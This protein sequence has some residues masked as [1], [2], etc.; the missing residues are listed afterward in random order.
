MEQNFRKRRSIVRR[1]DYFSVPNK[2]AADLVFDKFEKPY[3]GMLSDI[4]K[5]FSI[6]IQTVSDWYKR[7]KNDPTWR[8]YIGIS[9]GIHNRK[10]TDAEENNLAS[11][12]QENYIKPGKL[13]TDADCRDLIMKAFQEKHKDK[14]KMP[15]FEISDHFISN[16]KERNNISSIPA[17]PSGFLLFAQDMK[18]QIRSENPTLSLLEISRI[19][20]K[21][22]KEVPYDQKVQYKQKAAQIH[23]EFKRSHPDYTYTKSK[24]KHLNES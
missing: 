5:G 9:R 1:I 6:P 13:F 18:P 10:L 16:F 22:W 7:Y 15:E 23:E 14:E 2:A 8:P 20:G 11:F 4:H 17:R 19:L 12:I 3:Y 21:M 24:K